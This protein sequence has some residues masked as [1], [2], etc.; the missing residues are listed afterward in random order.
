MAALV[1]ILASLFLLFFLYCV[2][3]FFL[4]NLLFKDL[5][6]A[7]PPLHTHEKHLG[8]VSIM[9]SAPPCHDVRPMLLSSPFTS[10]AINSRLW[11]LIWLQNN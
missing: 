3:V 11:S 5:M 7:A 1:P 10:N 4:Y 9:T 8:V 2:N 6:I